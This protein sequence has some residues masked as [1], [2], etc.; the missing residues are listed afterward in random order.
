[1]GPLGSRRIRKHSETNALVRYQAARLA[2]QRRPRNCFVAIEYCRIEDA[3]AAATERA[4]P[5]PDRCTPVSV[6][7]EDVQS[8][9]HDIAL[10]DFYVQFETQPLKWTV[11]IVRLLQYRLQQRL[12]GMGW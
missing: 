7:Y 6:E 12:K 11:A 9:V 8:L 1:M 4:R 5:T 3:K 10:G 2:A